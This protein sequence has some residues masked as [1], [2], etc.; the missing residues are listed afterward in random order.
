MRE[1]GVRGVRGVEEREEGL[2]MYEPG[3]K[4]EQDGTGG[5][6]VVGGRSRDGRWDL[7]KIGRGWN[8]KWEE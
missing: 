6:C 7:K 8:L 3:G 2:K 4:A 5:G 1:R